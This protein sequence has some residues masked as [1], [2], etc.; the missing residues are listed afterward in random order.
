MYIACNKSFKFLEIEI[1]VKPYVRHFLKKNLEG[2]EPF[3]LRSDSEVGLMLLMGVISREYLRIVF[4]HSGEIPEADENDT[5]EVPLPEGRVTIKFLLPNKYNRHVITPEV[6][7]RMG[8]VLEAI[9]KLFLLGFAQGYKVMFYSDLAAAN[10]FLQLYGFNED[11]LTLANAHKI[12]QRGGAIKFKDQMRGKTKRRK[13][14]K[15][16]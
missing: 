13:S 4:D 10:S 16:V 7:L 14:V 6:L 11:D 9:V 3:Y 1:P 8:E 5:I 2:P 15:Y 12:I